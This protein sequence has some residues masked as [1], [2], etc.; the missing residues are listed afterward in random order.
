[1]SRH[2]LAR[3]LLSILAALFLASTA[4]PAE[5]KPRGWWISQDERESLVLRKW[6]ICRNGALLTI[7]ADESAG[8]L[9][10]LIVRSPT[11]PDSE[12]ER[13][14]ARRGIRLEDRPLRIRYL[15]RRTRPPTVMRDSPNRPPDQI[16]P[17]PASRYRYSTT[18][19]LPWMKLPWRSPPARTVRLTMGP[20]GH[21]PDPGI[22]RVR[23]C[24][25]LGRAFS[26]AESFNALTAWRFRAPEPPIGPARAQ[27]AQ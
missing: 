18:V 11:Q 23:N 2:S 14:L 17:P 22:L 21:D 3:A 15:W 9:L 27:G 16:I 13:V 19:K 7:A 24:L 26:W 4:T 8:P 10:K 5:A 1:M 25:L 12:E 6:L 20:V